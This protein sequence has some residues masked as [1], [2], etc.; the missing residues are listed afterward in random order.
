VSSI[1]FRCRRCSIVLA[2]ECESP[3]VE[4]RR[5]IESGQGLFE[6]HECAP[7][8]PG[9]GGGALGILDLIGEGERPRTETAA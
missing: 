7:A 3:E 2:R 4:I 1:V 9:R 8:L 5:R 6:L